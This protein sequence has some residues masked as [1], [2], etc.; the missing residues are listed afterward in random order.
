L[1][2]LLKTQAP[3]FFG[4]AEVVGKWVWIHFAEEQP[5]EITARLAE[6]GFHWNSKRQSWQHPCGEFRQRPFSGDPRER[7]GSQ[8]PADSQ[9][10]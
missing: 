8:F 4:M 9:A 2:D 7:Y 1:L 3:Q 6:F 5:R 10:A